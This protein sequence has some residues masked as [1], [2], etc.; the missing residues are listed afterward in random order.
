V[1]KLPILNRYWQPSHKNRVFL[2]ADSGQLLGRL[3]LRGY[4]SLLDLSP[5]GTMLLGVTD[6]GMFEF[7]NVPPRKPVTSFAVAAATLAM[8]IA[9]LACWRS[10]RPRRK[11][12]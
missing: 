8:P 4:Q 9:G 12:A 2:D 7:W 6:G 5:N 1:A 11:V 10:R 3:P